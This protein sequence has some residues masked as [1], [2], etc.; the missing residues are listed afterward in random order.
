MESFFRSIGD[1]RDTDL[2]TELA[3]LQI[4]ALGIYGAKDNI[5]SP[6]NAALLAHG[7]DSSEIAIMNKSRHFPMTDEPGRFVSV[8]TRFLA[9]AA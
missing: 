6:Q 3:N 4:P 7:V 8:M 1:L 2:S 9:D 5:V